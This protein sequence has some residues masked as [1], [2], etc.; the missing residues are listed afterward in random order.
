[1]NKKI[2]IPLIALIVVLAGGVLAWLVWPKKVET[3]A[4]VP[5]TET[6]VV[7]TPEEVVIRFFHE[8]LVMGEIIRHVPV[9]ESAFVTEEYKQKIAR[10]RALPVW[11]VDPVI[12]AQDIPEGISLG[13]A[14]ITGDT[15]LLI[16]TLKYSF[17]REGGHNLKV[18]LLLV[19]NQW[20][21]NNITLINN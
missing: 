3:P 12:F 16:A 5:A 11:A 8:Y 21:I 7:K 15:A 19:N 13:K 1:M 6:P 17:G 4:L 2:V 14:T 9:S 10:V 20:K 18:E